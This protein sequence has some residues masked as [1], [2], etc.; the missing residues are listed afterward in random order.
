MA[1]LSRT[2][3]AAEPFKVHRDA[4]M[5]RRARSPRDRYPVTVT[6]AHPEAWATAIAIAHGDRSRLRVVDTSTV[7]VVNPP[8]RP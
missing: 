3:G 8:H 4:A 6:R 1:K 5:K 7:V 2:S